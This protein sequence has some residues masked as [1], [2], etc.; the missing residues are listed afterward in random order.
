MVTSKGFARVLV[1]WLVGAAAACGGRGQGLSSKVGGTASKELS[2]G[3]FK[4][5]SRECSNPSNAPQ[6][7][8]RMQFLELTK[9]HF[10][11]VQPDQTALVVWLASSPEDA[12]FT[13]QARALRG[14]FT[15]ENEYVVDEDPR[16]REWL[17]FG[18]NGLQGYAY[19]RF[20]D[21]SHGTLEARV[22]LTLRSLPRTPALGQ[23]LAYPEGD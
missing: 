9:G 22:R 18:A 23:R 21:A 19:E 16:S 5:V 7:C 12:Q 6:D 15:S 13:Y 1:L 4:V 20:A 17:V 3:L 2:D 14:R 10:F 11:G 8:P